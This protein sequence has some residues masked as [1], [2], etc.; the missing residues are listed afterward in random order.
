M[1]GSRMKKP[2]RF[3]S[4][5][6][7]AER[8]RDEE[9]FQA[10]MA[11]KDRC[12]AAAK[13]YVPTGALYRIR[14]TD[15]GHYVIERRRVERADRWSELFGSP[16]R[17]YEAANYEN[18]DSTPEEVYHALTEG[19]DDLTF[20]I[21]DEAESYLER[22]ARQPGE[23]IIEYDYPPLKKRTPKEQA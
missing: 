2:D 1:F 23:K 5:E 3:L 10:Y 14:Q 8:K 6:T 22:V 16:W 12:A 9:G 18:R 17:A 11:W 19:G 4:G 20:N 13:S 15:A 21:F 7:E